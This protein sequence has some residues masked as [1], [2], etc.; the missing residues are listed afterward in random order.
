M[1][2]YE[3]K[4]TR[5]Q[6]EIL[7][8]LIIKA[9]MK[10]NQRNIARALNVSPTAVSKSLKDLEKSEL[11]RVKKDP[12]MNL[13]LV[14]FDRDNRK[15]IEFKR[16][17][18]LK[19]IYESRIVEILEEK[20]P[21]GIIILFGSYSFGE[22]TIK[23]DIDFAVIGTKNKIIDLEKHERAFERKIN[24]NTYKNFKDIDKNLRNNILNGIV[25]VGR[26]EL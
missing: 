24:I 25:L 19:M 18:N 17:E 1:D 3:L 10:V 6:N 16:V 26:V 2:T 23:S 11:V 8:F 15:A 4:F 21:G 13:S 20:F 9:G 12:L 5:L 14:E 7:R 22:D